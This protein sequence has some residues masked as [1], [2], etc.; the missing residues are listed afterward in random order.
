MEADVITRIAELARENQKVTI[1][2]LPG[3]EE[4]IVAKPDGETTVRSVP[5]PRR[6]HTV[7][8]VEEIAKAYHTAPNDARVWYSYGEVVLLPKDAE[9][10]DRYTLQLTASDQVNRLQ[11]ISGKA[12]TQRDTIKTLIRLDVDSSTIAVFRRLD[13]SRT[14][15]GHAVIQRDKES[16][17]KSVEAEVTATRE[18]PE[19]LT[20]HIP[21]FVNPRLRTRYQVEVLMDIDPSS[22]MITLEIAPNSLDD[23]TNEAM[24]HLRQILV[25]MDVNGEQIYFGTP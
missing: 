2:V 11:E 10:R 14:E 23:A 22:S 20:L 17:G 9:R 6:N 16:M 5:V 25:E 24:E 15:K 13:F 18:I 8:T 7:Y 21:L 12:Q 4:Y 3:G 1:E 19:R